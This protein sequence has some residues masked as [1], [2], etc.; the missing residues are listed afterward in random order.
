MVEVSGADGGFVDSGRPLAGTSE[1]VGRIAELRRLDTLIAGGARLIT[2][3]GP[4][5]IGKTRLAAEALRRMEHHQRNHVHWARLAEL[6]RD[7]VGADEAVVQ[8]IVR[9]S[10]VGASETA[11]GRRI[12]V[13]DNCEHVLPTVARVVTE[14]LPAAPD[15]TVLATSR[16]P[17]GWIDEY[18]VV[19][20]PLSPAQ[21]LTLLRQRSEL[22][23]R[24]I[25]DDPAQIDIAERICRHVDHSPL[26]VRLAAA[27]LRHQPPA[28]VLRELTGDTDDKRMRWSH[29]ARAGADKR[30]RGVYDVIEWSYRLCTAGEQVLLERLSVFAAGY[31]THREHA[32]RNGIELADVVAVCAGGALSAAD[33]EYLIERLAE[34]S[35]VSTHVTE[36]SV[37]WYLVESVKVF[38]RHRLQVRGAAESDRMTDR[39]RRY[40]RDRVV[41]WQVDWFGPREQAWLDWVLSA[42]DNIV[43]GIE[44]GLG[45]PATA[46]TGLDTAAVLLAAWVPSMSGD[47]DAITWVTE[48]ALEATRASS[49]DAA[50][51]RMRAAAMLAWNAVWQGDSDRAARLLDDCVACCADLTANSAWRENSSVDIGLPAHVE[52]TWGLE[53]TLV[54][55]DSRAITVLDRAHR[56]FVESGDRI[57]REGSDLFRAMACAFLG[58]RDTALRASRDYLDRALPTG[59]PSAN[60]WARILR[61]VALAAHGDA[62]EAV[63]ITDRLL[64]ELRQYDDMWITNWA[65]TARIVALARQLAERRPGDGGHIAHNAVA[66]EILTLVTGLEQADPSAGVRIGAIPLVAAETR[67]AVQVARRFVDGR[68]VGGRDVSGPVG[69]SRAPDWDSLSPAER[70]IAVLAAAGWSNS[71]IAARRGSSTRTVDAQVASIRQK[72]AVASRREIVAHVP[73]DLAERIELEARNW[74]ERRRR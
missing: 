56:K 15:L 55:R 67:R 70:E 10:T 22:T 8:S 61:A 42:W 59:S 68:A 6:E 50:E 46:H 21:S 25:L 20:A 65:E 14:L 54:H 33:V 39:H 53:L 37:R 62:A 29:G 48:R 1:F 31:D 71:A 38:A 64:A 44:A 35:L 11:T 74:A 63:A 72:L 27:R 34:R 12:L 24:P 66:A 58:D 16:E 26:F 73:G 60:V 3:V 23:G 57:G 18:V 47:G 52:W 41:A 40:Y 2:L 28:M 13:L 36:T 19:V 45:D 49:G 30:H 43:I 7:A 32:V 69:A 17:I 51:P 9:T 5:G 4:G